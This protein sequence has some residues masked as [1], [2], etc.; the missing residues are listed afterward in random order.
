ME[1]ISFGRK[2]NEDRDKR[3]NQAKPDEY[4][5]E[6]AH[7]VFGNSNTSHGEKYEDKMRDG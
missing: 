5:Q 4:L 7:V 3:N 6:G 2:A 1:D